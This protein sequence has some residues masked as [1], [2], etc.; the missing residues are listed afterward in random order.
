M[1]AANLC[2]EAVFR[3]DYMCMNTFYLFVFNKLLH[4]TV[5]HSV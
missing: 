5:K 1:T 4:V 2:R 3:L